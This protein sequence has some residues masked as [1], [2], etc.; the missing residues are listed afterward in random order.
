MKFNQLNGYIAFFM[1][2]FTSC[3]IFALNQNE[4]YQ[5]IAKTRPAYEDWLKDINSKLVTETQ[6]LR[7]WLSPYKDP[8]ANIITLSSFSTQADLEKAI[9]LVTNKARELKMPISWFVAPY[10]NPLETPNVL[11]KNGFF[12]AVS[13]EIVE[14]NL[15]NAILSNIH[16]SDIQIIPLKYAD[17]NAWMSIVASAFEYNEQLAQSCVEYI[18][19]DVKNNNPD[20][21]HFAGFF[22]GKLV[23]T[24]TLLIGQDGWSHVYD[25]ATLQHAQHKGMATAMMNYIIKRAKERNLKIINLMATAEG[26]AIYNKLGFKK[27]YDIDMFVFNA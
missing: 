7:F 3:F 6:E 13:Y 14:L 21:E 22:K 12:K 8:F 20:Q 10:M 18:K 1:A 23:T 17:I 25:I 5:I 24:G 2:L 4:I 15:E 27:L 11:I 19:R 26:K 9:A 16:S